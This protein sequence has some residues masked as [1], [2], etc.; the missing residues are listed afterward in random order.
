MWHYY[1][2]S[3]AEWWVQQFGTSMPFLSWLPF[4]GGIVKWYSFYFLGPK[5]LTV[6]NFLC[7]F[8]NVYT[9][10][11]AP[12]FDHMENIIFMAICCHIFQAFI[13][14]VH[15]RNDSLCS[16]DG[17]V[18]YLIGIRNLFNLGVNKELGI[19][20]QDLLL[21]C[22]ELLNFVFV[23]TAMLLSSFTVFWEGKILCAPVYD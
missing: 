12:S 20:V 16:P 6:S 22:F 19:P 8:H 10:S 2:Y 13:W 17:S 18:L 21:D 3:G 15:R 4:I 14:H 9:C 5:G 1:Y 7:Y 23:D 11:L